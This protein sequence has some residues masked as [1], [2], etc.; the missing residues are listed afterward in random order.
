MHVKTDKPPSPWMKRTNGNGQVHLPGPGHSAKAP[1]IRPLECPPQHQTTRSTATGPGHP[2]LGFSPKNQTPPTP[3]HFP[4]SPAPNRKKPHPTQKHTQAGP[5][6]PDIRPP[7][8]DIRPLPKHRTSG[9]T[10]GHPAPPV[11]T[12]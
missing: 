9:P 11:C 3:N 7:S 4:E 5:A 6:S 8:P 10:P 1:D 2:A 12:Q